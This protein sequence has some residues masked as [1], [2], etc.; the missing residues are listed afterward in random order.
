MQGLQVHEIAET[1]RDPASQSKVVGKVE[2]LQ[3]VQVAQTL[4][5]LSLDNV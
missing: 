5:H 1:L 2:V 4:R 3:R